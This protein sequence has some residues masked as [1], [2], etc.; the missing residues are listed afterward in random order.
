MLNYM[1]VTVSVQPEFTHYAELKHNIDMRGEVALLTR[2]VKIRGEV[3]LKCPQA[4]GNCHQFAY[5][6]HGG[7]IKV[8]L[9]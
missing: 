2:N 5:D 7:Q 8:K 6:T 4:N 3:Q 9:Y 1:P